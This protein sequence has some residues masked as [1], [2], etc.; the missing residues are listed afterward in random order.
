VLGPRHVR[1]MV[2][3]AARAD[4]LMLQSRWRE[5]AAL[6]E[7]VLPVLEAAP[8]TRFD[9]ADFTCKLSRA[10]V[11]LH[12][13]ARALDRLERQARTLD[14]LSPDLRVAVEFALARA[15]WDSRGDRKRAHELAVRASG[16]IRAI[17]DAPR[18]DVVE[19]ERWLAS[20]RLR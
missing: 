10:Y 3:I 7:S 20:H 4:V 9:V 18:E 1:V 16:E 13:P 6:Y 14:A 8:G 19:I 2:A 12:R 5:A 17:A 11:E 15:L